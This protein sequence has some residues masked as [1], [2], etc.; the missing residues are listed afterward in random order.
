[1]DKHSL[2]FLAANLETRCTRD[3]NEI[4]SL[5]QMIE[6]MTKIVAVSRNHVIMKAA[7]VQHGD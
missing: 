6:V 2:M 4:V 1:M 7:K 5:H 3:Q